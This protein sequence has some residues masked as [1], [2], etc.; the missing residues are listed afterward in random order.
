MANKI[1]DHIRR[2]VLEKPEE[3]RMIASLDDQSLDRLLK[4]MRAN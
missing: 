2:R 4:G 1:P 3:F